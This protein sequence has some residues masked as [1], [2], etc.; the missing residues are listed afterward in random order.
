MC[1]DPLGTGLDVA[2]RAFHLPTL[3]GDSV[4]STAT[5]NAHR[6]IHVVSPA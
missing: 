6:M 3:G 2:G 4:A 5:I 1:D